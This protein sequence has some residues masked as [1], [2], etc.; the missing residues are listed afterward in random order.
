MVSQQGGS[1]EDTKG[2]QPRFAGALPDGTTCAT[3]F[4]Q[5]GG[6]TE[7]QVCLETLGTIF[8]SKCASQ[9]QETPCLCG[10]TDPAACLAGAATPTG[11]DYDQY[12][13]DFDSASIDDIQNDF[14]NQVFG[15]GQANAIVQCA[16]AFNCPCF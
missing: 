8:G 12:I 10:S 15:A 13:C 16:A 14:T 6:E 3:V 7:T 4:A 11:P 9:F 1:C 5:G 2:I